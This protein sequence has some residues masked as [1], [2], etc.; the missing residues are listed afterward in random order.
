[1]MEELTAFDIRH[2]MNFIDNITFS[3]MFN[4]FFIP[5]TILIA[6][7]FLGIWINRLI[8][9]KINSRFE[10]DDITLQYV[11]IRSFQG[12]PGTWCTITGIYWSINSLEIAPPVTSLLS[13]FIFIFL[14]LT[15]CRV[16]SNGLAGFFDLYTQKNAN[17]P[18][19]TLFT[20]IAMVLIYAIGVVII[21][22]HMGISV[23]PILTAMGVG[24]MAVALAL[25]D[26]LANVFSGM[27]LIIT[28]QIKIGDYIKLDHNDPGQVSDI[29]W[30]Y[31]TLHTPL[32]NAVI[33][34]NKTIAGATILNYN[35]P[36]TDI[37]IVIPI[38]V[39]Y[40]SDLEQ[41]EQVTLEV[42]NDITS[43]CDPEMTI[44]PT[45]FFTEFAD[46][47]INFEVRLHC[48]NF[49]TRGR[50]RHMFIKAITARYREEGIN[51]P[52]PIRTVHMTK[53]N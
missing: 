31:T 43:Q 29:S 14:V 9:Q 17:M 41:V 36:I 46:S 21:L 5:I 3:E 32:G 51:I 42:A 6:F 39:G 53:E 37:T 24:G 15:I 16:I 19:T 50:M 40:E 33:V 27:Q 48:S 47:S 45:L 44:K 49:T 52:F 30:R 10:N 2:F 22:D 12:L 35:V 38:G 26:T 25:Q 20:N 13:Y 28:K 34:P 4:M 7:I 18:K 1:M 11:M 23:A 8:K